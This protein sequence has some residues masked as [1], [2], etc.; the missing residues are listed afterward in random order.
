M[1]EVQVGDEHMADVTRGEAEPTQ[2]VGTRFARALRDGLPEDVGGAAVHLRHVAEAGIHQ[3]G[4]VA[5]QDQPE[6]EAIVK[7]LGRVAAMEGVVAGQL[8]ATVAQRVDPI[9]RRGRARRGRV[10]LRSSSRREEALSE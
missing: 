10:R 8:A 1:V 5:S 2:L 6:V 4:P 9:E 7:R 3:D